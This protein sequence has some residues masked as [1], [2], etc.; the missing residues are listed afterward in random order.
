MPVEIVYGAFGAIFMIMLNDMRT[1]IKEASE[2]VSSLNKN[3]AVL[4][5]RV[6]RL[7]EESIDHRESILKLNNDVQEIKQRI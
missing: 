7:D 6:E 5:E 3:V 2:S 1:S 4:L